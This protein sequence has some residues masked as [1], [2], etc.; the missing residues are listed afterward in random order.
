MSS[1]NVTVHAQSCDE[2]R[3]SF[4]SAMVLWFGISAG[5]WSLILRMV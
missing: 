1:L 2:A 4:L 3:L 5:G